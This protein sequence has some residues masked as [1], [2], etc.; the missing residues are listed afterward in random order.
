MQGILQLPPMP[1]VFNTLIPLV[2][3]N[4]S[5][6]EIFSHS[7]DSHSRTE[8]NCHSDLYLNF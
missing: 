8:Q 6:V 7:W 1:V 2:Q 3:Y 4:L 5:R